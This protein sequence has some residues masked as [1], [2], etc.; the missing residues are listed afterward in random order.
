MKK[1]KNARK[2]VAIITNNNNRGNNKFARSPQRSRAG[3]S[4]APKAT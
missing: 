4:I 1:I 2:V 3:P